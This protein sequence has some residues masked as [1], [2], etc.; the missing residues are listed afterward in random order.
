MQQPARGWRREDGDLRASLYTCQ[1]YT[2]SLHLLR[3]T[4]LLRFTPLRSA[5]LHFLSQ[6]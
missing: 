5:P 3:F 2:L 4:A 1:H 6:S